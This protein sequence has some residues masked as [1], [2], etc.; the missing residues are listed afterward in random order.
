MGLYGSKE[1][2]GPDVGDEV[3]DASDDDDADRIKLDE[4]ILQERRKKINEHRSSVLARLAATLGHGDEAGLVAV[5]D[6]M[7][8]YPDPAVLFRSEGTVA[9]LNK[10]ALDALRLDPGSF[11]P[12]APV[13]RYLRFP[14]R[15]VGSPPSY[16]ALARDEFVNAKGKIAHRP[17]ADML[18]RT[19]SIALK[20]APL[21]LTI[22]FPAASA[23][24]TVL[25]RPRDMPDLA[26]S[27]SDADSPNSSPRSPTVESRWPHGDLTITIRSE[28]AIVGASHGF[29]KL[30]SYSD[31]ELRDV[32]LDTLLDESSSASSPPSLSA[33]I[34]DRNAPLH[35]KEKMPQRFTLRT[36]PGASAVP[37]VSVSVAGVTRVPSTDFVVARLRLYESA[38]TRDAKKLA[39]SFEGGLSEDITAVFDQSK[40]CVVVTTLTGSILYCN[41]PCL[42][43]LDYSAHQVAHKDI[44]LLVPAPFKESHPAALKNIFYSVDFSFFG[45][46]RAT[47]T[48]TRTGRIVPIKLEV[49]ELKTPQSRFLYVASFRILA[50]DL[51]NSNSLLAHLVHLCAEHRQDEETAVEERL[52]RD[53][54]ERL[55]KEVAGGSS[56][57]RPSRLGLSVSMPEMPRA[58]FVGGESLYTPRISA[59]E[60]ADPPRSTDSS[61]H[62]SSSLRR[63]NSIRL[64]S[65]RRLDNLRRADS[66]RRSPR[67]R[68]L[69]PTVGD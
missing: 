51:A 19:L 26:F 16:A 53:R 48:I 47:V 24:Q 17:D 30:I 6:A 60:A 31:E 66:L 3:E 25:R 2:S 23:R 43:L 7:E 63:S 13:G 9:H 44:S 46:P 10:A 22:F 69:L 12:G 45:A 59:A 32:Q 27:D 40:S 37:R 18:T 64:D 4:R 68:G 11:R 1:V 39:F 49:T 34:A 56:G 5:V 65:L 50:G 52:V 41:D 61:L 8:Q 14:S 28:G 54:E 58:S 55:R 29:Q 42:E 67:D 38:A 62:R 15:V 36:K 35:I 57:R 20:P 33:V 21:L